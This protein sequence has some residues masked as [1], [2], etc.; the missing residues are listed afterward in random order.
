MS[1]GGPASSAQTGISKRLII[2]SAQIEFQ[3][4]EGMTYTLEQLARDLQAELSRASANACAENLCSLVS[5]AL[6]DDDFV[7]AH[8]PDRAEGE[9][10][11]ELLYE[12]PDLGFCICGHVY[13]GAA[14]SAPHDHGSSWAIYGQAE[15]TT[16]MTDWKIVD[17]GAQDR[18]IRVTPERTYQLSRGDAHFYDV[19]AV[20]SPKRTSV[21]RLVRVEGANLDQIQRSHIEVA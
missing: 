5:R 15:G 1:D 18:P 3:M 12:D 14:E 19:G 13:E 17:V 6:V 9:D 2:R 20:H 8:L 10:P 7:A 4:R 11:R 16:E 21:T